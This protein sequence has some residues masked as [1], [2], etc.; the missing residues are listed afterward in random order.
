KGPPELKGIVAKPL[1]K[2]RKERYQ[3]AKDLLI[4]LRNLKRRLEVDAEIDRTMPAEFRAAASTSSG[5]S[6]PATVSGTVAA[7]APAGAPRSASSAE[8]IVSGIKQHKLA[9]ALAVI[10][11]VVGAAGLS[12]YLHA[13]NSEVAIES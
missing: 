3:T 9:V 1:T 13:R 6:P 5:Q 8:Y 12:A 4:D 7:T 11:L 10:V 2:N